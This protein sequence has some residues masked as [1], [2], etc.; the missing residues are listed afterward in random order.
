M[1]GPAEQDVL[2][3]CAVLDPRLLGYVGEWPDDVNEAGGF[4][5][6]AEDG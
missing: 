3:D 2:L 6:V 1:H 4:V 5:C